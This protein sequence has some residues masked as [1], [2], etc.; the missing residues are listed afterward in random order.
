MPIKFLRLPIYFILEA[1]IKQIRLKGEFCLCLLC[2]SK[3]LLL[4]L[5]L[6]LPLDVIPVVCGR[7]WNL[8]SRRAGQAWGLCTKAH[9]AV[10][11]LS[12]P[13]RLGQ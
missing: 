8:A 10:M 4:V 11:S 3:Q 5:S 9:H 12:S 6:R 7:L 2:L 13:A 1:A